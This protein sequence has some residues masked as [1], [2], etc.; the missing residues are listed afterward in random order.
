MLNC[1]HSRSICSSLWTP[2]WQIES[3]FCGSEKVEG[4]KDNGLDRVTVRWHWSSMAKTTTQKCSLGW[5]GFSKTKVKIQDIRVSVSKPPPP[6]T[7]QFHF[8]YLE[9]CTCPNTYSNY[10]LHPDHRISPLLPATPVSLWLKYCNS[11]M[12]QETPQPFIL[13]HFLY[14]HIQFLVEAAPPKIKCMAEKGGRERAFKW[15]RTDPCPVLF[16]PQTISGKVQTKLKAAVHAASP[17]TATA[18]FCL[19]PWCFSFSIIF[20]ISIYPGKVNRAYK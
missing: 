5:Q 19:F 2:G 17:K 1:D 14:M 9:W 18:S 12:P 8:L 15:L 3:S 16:A 13:L 20:N 11:K 4:E 10:N 7:R 6:K